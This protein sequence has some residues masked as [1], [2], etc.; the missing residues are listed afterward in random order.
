MSFT[1]DPN[2]KY[3]KSHEWVRIEEDLGDDAVFGVGKIKV[4]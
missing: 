3:S 4:L 1:V 2:A